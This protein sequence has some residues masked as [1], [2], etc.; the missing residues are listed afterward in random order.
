[1]YFR[2]IIEVWMEVSMYVFLRKRWGE[3]LFPS[4]VDRIVV[5]SVETHWDTLCLLGWEGFNE[6]RLDSGL[7]VM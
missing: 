1:M 2:H 4:I 5:C 3:V 7:Y 6:L